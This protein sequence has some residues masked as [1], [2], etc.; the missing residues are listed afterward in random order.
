VATVRVFEIA[1]ILGTTSAE[2]IARLKS[3]L[4]VEATTASTPIGD[5]VARQFIGQL[6]RERG[7]EL[8]STMEPLWRLPRALANEVFQVIVKAG[9]KPS[10]FGWERT[11]DRGRARLALRGTPYAF[12]FT[13]PPSGCSWTPPLADGATVVAATHWAQE[14]RAFRVWLKTIAPE[15]LEPDLWS[16]IRHVRQFTHLRG[17]DSEDSPFSPAERTAVRRVLVE[18]EAQ[19]QSRADLNDAQCRDVHAR[20]RYLSEAL[21]RLRKIDWLN[22]FASQLV[23]L[24]LDRLIAPDVVNGLFGAAA[25]GLRTIL[26][27]GTHLLGNGE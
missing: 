4:G 7:I 22:L 9:L 6:A 13:L 16:Q 19:V 12:L 10:A 24:A 1:E 25:A 14:V 2:V 17:N 3:E 11:T 18:L 8:S 5:E 23:F 21:D 27:F 15:L 26:D 20:F